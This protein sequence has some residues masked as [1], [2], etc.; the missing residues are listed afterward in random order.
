LKF[1]NQ[2]I[3]L[4]DPLIPW[5][6]PILGIR[7]RK[8]AQALDGVSV[9]RNASSFSNALDKQGRCLRAGA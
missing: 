4:I 6:I 3:C 9:E 5:K 2:A 7:I 1:K 8:I